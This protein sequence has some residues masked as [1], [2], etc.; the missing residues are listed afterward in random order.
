MCHYVILV[1][2]GDMGCVSILQ[3]EIRFSIIALL[4]LRAI[5]INIAV[6]A[7]FG[8]LSLRRTI[9][10]AE[11]KRFCRCESG[12]FDASIRFVDNFFFGLGLFKI[13]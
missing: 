1:Y 8:Q 12:V 2:S 6:M 4:V 13:D 7:N 11:P 3:R 9:L 10:K 5:I